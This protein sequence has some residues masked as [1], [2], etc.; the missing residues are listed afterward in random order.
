MAGSQRQSARRR[1]TN[2]IRQAAIEAADGHR[3]VLVLDMLQMP[4]WR[5]SPPL[6]GSFCV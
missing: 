1:R 5:A 6:R 4:R 2:L 3:Q